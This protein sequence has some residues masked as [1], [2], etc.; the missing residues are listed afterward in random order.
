[1]GQNRRMSPLVRVDIHPSQFPENMRAQLLESLHT[2]RL[3]HKF[4][5]ES[6][7]QTTQWLALHEAYSP[8]RTDPGCAAAYER[9]F[10]EVLGRLPKTAVELVGL[11]CGGGR[12]DTQLIQGLRGGNRA[13]SYTPLDVSTAMVLV[14]H[15]TAT[16]FIPASNCFPL[17]C[18]L[19][20]ADDL[21]EH[22][23]QRFTEANAGGSQVQAGPRIFTFFGMIPNFEPDVILPKLAKLIRPADHL[24]F[25]ANLAPGPH[26]DDGVKRVL[27]LYDNDLTREWLML[28]LLDLGVEK[29]DG[30][31]RFSIENDASL[32]RITAC[33]EFRRR[34]EIQVDAERFVFTP[35]AAIRLFFSYRH[36]PALVRSLLRAHRLD[37]LAEWITPSADEGIFLVSAR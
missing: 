8:F 21:S 22:L 29:E 17:V 4:H 34:R 16:Q 13:V 27:P 5:Y 28:V 7:K 19:A 26:Y 12:K 3:N 32:K 2:R 24:L 18:D 1:M 36:T 10:D 31:I 37:V 25:G 15:R 30:T 11:G 35:G 20:V 6:V 14:A 33:F 23:A 9:C